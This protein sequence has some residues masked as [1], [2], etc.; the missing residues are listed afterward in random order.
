MGTPVVLVH[1][2][3]P[4]AGEMEDK[5]RPFLD[6]QGWHNRMMAYAEGV[7]P[8]GAWA[9]PFWRHTVLWATA[10]LVTTLVFVALPRRHRRPMW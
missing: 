8:P 4:N 10:H 7:L 9:R 6:H 1:L 2:G 3:F 5:G